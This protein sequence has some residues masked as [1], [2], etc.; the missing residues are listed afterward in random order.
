MDAQIKKNTISLTFLQI[1]NYLVP[2]VILPYLARVLGVDGFGQMAFATAFTA[3]FI[4]VVDWG[5]NLVATRAISIN[6]SNRSERSITFWETLFSRLLLTVLSICILFALILVFPKLER[7]SDLLLM[8]VLQ[9]LAATLSTF[10]YYQGIERMSSMALINLGIRTLSIPLILWLVQ[11]E[12]QVVLA[13]GLQTACFLMASLTNLILL[14]KTREI[15]LIKP[16]WSGVQRALANAFPLFLSSA[17][18]S[19][20]TNSNAVILGLISTEWVVGVFVAGFTLVKA[21]VGLSG[22]FAQAIFPRASRELS[23]TDGIPKAFLRKMLS[24]QVLLGMALSLGLFAFMPWGVT[25]FYGDAFEETI[26]V[27]A[28]LSLLPLLVCVASGL[29][30]NILVPLG[31][32]RWYSSVLIGCGL[33][34]C[35]MLAILGYIWGATGAAVA[36]LMTECLIMFGMAIGVRK[37]APEVWHSLVKLP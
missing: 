26:N 31:E 4:L 19:L 22:P 37:L 17:G 20:Y 34:N 15:A 7:V 32:H 13:Y 9:V 18:T 16:R 1:G 11:H 33:L 10:F 24:I 27:V 14:L 3:Y 6:R 30:L 28:W 2:L 23:S 25:W 29:G 5:F 21:V 12:D 35:L 36:V 8:G